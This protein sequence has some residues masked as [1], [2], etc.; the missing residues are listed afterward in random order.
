MTECNTA[1]Q[2]QLDLQ[3]QQ[4]RQLQAEQQWKMMQDQQKQFLQYLHE[5]RITIPQL[6]QQQNFQQVPQFQH[7]LQLQL[8][9]QPPQQNVSNELNILE[10]NSAKRQRTY[11]SPDM[12]GVP[13]S[14]R[15]EIFTEDEITNEPVNTTPLVNT[16]HTCTR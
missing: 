13:V 4:N 7:S 15:Y 16:P 9:R 14:N 2:Q 1:T 3:T 10:K 6:Q 11:D 12:Y 8:S 5:Q